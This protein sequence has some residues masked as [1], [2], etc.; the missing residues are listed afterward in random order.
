MNPPREKTIAQGAKAAAVNAPVSGAR[1]PW[2]S[3]VA[4]AARNHRTNAL[5]K[6]H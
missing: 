2:V 6:F 4:K 3:A 1:L 5:L